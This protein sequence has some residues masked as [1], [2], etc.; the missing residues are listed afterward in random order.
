MGLNM[1]YIQWCCQTWDEMS[2]AFLNVCELHL[3]PAPVA[4]G[5]ALEFYSRRVVDSV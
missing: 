1:Q 2:N 4:A 3:Q 5:A